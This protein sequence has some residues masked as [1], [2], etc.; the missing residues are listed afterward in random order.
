MTKDLS[1]QLC[2]L[3][4]IKP[5]YTIMINVSTFYTN[6]QKF[7]YK[8]K[9]A[10]LRLHLGDFN[11][12]Y[13]KHNLEGADEDCVNLSDIKEEFVDFKLPENSVKLLECLFQFPFD[14]EEKETYM[15]SILCGTIE[16]LKNEECADLKQALQAQ[17]WTY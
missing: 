10:L 11:E 4:E 14:C 17:N 15:K 2:E 12:Y 6:Y 5:V 7:V 8:S 13:S 16:K 9:F 3:A 1:Q